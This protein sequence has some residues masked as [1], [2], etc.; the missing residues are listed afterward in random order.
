MDFLQFLKRHLVLT[1]II[2]LLFGGLGFVYGT[3]QQGTTAKTTLFITIATQNTADPEASEVAATYFGETIMGWFRNPV[4]TNSVIE[5]AKVQNASLSALKQERQNMLVEA[6]TSSAQDAKTLA[7]EA[8]SKL[9]QEVSRYNKAA[10]SSFVIIDQGRSTRLSS[11]NT[12]VFPLAGLLLGFIIA[13]SLLGLKEFSQNSI[14]SRQEAEE[15]LGIKTLDFLKKEWEKNDLTLLSVAIQKASPITILAGVGLSTDVLAVALAHKHSFFGEKIA[16]VDGD[17][18]ERS[19]QNTLGLSNRMKNLKG[20][21]DAMMNEDETISTSLI[22]QNTL[23]DNL[24]FLPA[25]KGAKF[26]TQV[27]SNIAQE[28]KTLIHTTLP[29]N[30]EVLRLSNASL[31][32]VVQI[33]KTKKRDLRRIK[34]VWNEDLRLIVVE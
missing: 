5:G 8:F 27:F 30:S 21:T 23:D 2:V 4:F 19:L 9:K 20:H 34:E 16:L 14:S 18:K 6:Q 33:G 3:K 12:V 25:G 13:I 7:S 31:F 29:N 11:T 28:M 32:L 1:L 24:K 17:L 15:I 26:L 10:Q 22:I